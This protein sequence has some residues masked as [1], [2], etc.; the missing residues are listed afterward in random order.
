MPLMT[1]NEIAQ[2]FQVSKTMIYRQVGEERWPYYRVAG[3]LRFDA[4]ELRE[5]FRR[6]PSQ[7]VNG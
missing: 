7:G 4:N 3:E 1:V 2:E 5:W 6:N